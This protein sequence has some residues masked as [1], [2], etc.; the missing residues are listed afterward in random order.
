[1]DKEKAT[2]AEI[3]KSYES[4]LKQVDDK[5]RILKSRTDIENMPSII[6]QQKYQEQI[7]K[8]LEEILGKLQAEEY[9]T[10]SDY[11]NSCY[12]E[13][14]LRTM[15]GMQ[16]QGVPFAMPIDQKAVKRAVELDSKISGGLYSKIVDDVSAFKRQISAEISRGIASSLSY[17]DIA[18][19]LRNASN[20]PISNA[21]RM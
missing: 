15:Y 19:N 1:M 2:I 9:K 12:T 21:S 8:Q 18:R 5:I 7:K 13:G 16:Q 3:K 6:H 11:L 17:T 14:F 4:A 20:V 10:T